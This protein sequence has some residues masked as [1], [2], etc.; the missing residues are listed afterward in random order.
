[1]ATRTVPAKKTSK[2]TPAATKKKPARTASA[3]PAPKRAPAVEKAP[4]SPEQAA[5]AFDAV[6]YRRNWRNGS[7]GGR[8]LLKNPHCDYGTA[9]MLYWL[10]APYFE[11]Q[12][13]TD[14]EI[15]EFARA[16]IALM[17]ELEQRLLARDFATAVVAFNPR[18]DMHCSIDPLDW[19]TP[20]P[21]HPPLLRPPPPA[22]LMEP[23]VPDPAWEAAGRPSG[24]P[25]WQPQKP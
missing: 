21:N 15:P 4:P 25:V 19:V 5:H 13:A 20:N 17:R 22:A 6:A 14:R 10:G 1:M 3:K 18:R 7:R 11:R 9:L 16:D 23:S 24:R 2:R 12:Y 8:A